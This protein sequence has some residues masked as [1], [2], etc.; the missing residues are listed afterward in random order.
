M[1]NK[2]LVKATVL[3]KNISELETFLQHLEQTHTWN[4]GEW[5]WIDELPEP[6]LTLNIK[7]HNDAD[8][9]VGTYQ[10]K[11]RQ[12]AVLLLLEVSFSFS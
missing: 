11:L 1:T 3:S 2:D 4:I 7:H 5:Q 8:Q 6:S 10:D 12:G 9:L